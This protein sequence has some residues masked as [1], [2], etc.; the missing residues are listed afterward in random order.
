ME[1]L[2]VSPLLPHEEGQAKATLEAGFKVVF[3]EGL[4]APCSRAANAI[5]G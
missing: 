3:P 2:K 4:E 5:T 1:E